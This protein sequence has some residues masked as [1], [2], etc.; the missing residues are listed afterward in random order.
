VRLER[1]HL[2]PFI[3]GENPGLRLRALRLAAY[4][5]CALAPELYE[6]YLRD[7]DAQVK[8][9]A[10]AAAA[11]TGYSAWPSYCRELAAQPTPEAVEPLRVLAAV[12]GVD[13]YNLVGAVAADVAAGPDRFRVLGSFGHPYFIE[14]LIKE[15]E[16]P[17]PVAAVGAGAAFE[18]MTGQSPES[19]HRTKVSPDGN[20]P[21]DEFEAEFQ[22]EVFLPDPELARKHWQEL[23]PRLAS[24]PRICRGMD[25]SQPLSRE[26]FVALDMESRWEHCLRARLFS[27]WQGTPLVLERYPQRF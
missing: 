7:D 5:G 21:A 16:N 26:Q 10:L 12:A 9:A 15:M 8:D 6:V 1:Q 4:A 20:P 19:D 13:D 17:D 25:V 27:G 11:W 3:L 14:L 23:A 18:K 2:E 22:D 24:S